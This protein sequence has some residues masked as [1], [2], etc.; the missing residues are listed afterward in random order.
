MLREFDTTV[1]ERSDQTFDQ[2][3]LSSILF[4]ALQGTMYSNRMHVA[5]RRIRQVADDE[6]AALMS[7]F[8]SRDAQPIEARGAHLLRQG[9][10]HQSII[11]LTSALRKCAPELTDHPTSPDTAIQLLETYTS[12]LL[13]GYFA[14]HEEELRHEQ[15]LT[16]EAYVRT[17]QS[18]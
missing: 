16:H 18:Q 6:V 8:S 4:T 7:L 13:T 12:A 10:G 2:D 5:P 1:S 9:L 3:Q 17:L 15:Q 14:A 11:Q